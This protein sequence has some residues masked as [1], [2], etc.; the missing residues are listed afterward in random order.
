[1]LHL[2]D[3]QD[4]IGGQGIHGRAKSQKPTVGR[5]R[6]KRLMGTEDRITTE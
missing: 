1:L 2:I 3:D 4:L 6:R 5:A